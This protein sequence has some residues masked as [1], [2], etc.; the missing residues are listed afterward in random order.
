MLNQLTRSLAGSLLVLAVLPLAMAQELSAPRAQ[1]APSISLVA[2]AEG[3]NPVIAPNTWVEIKGAN[4]APANDTR[5][6]AGSDFVDNAL[7]VALD[8]VSVTVNGKPA[9]VYYISPIQINILTPPDAMPANVQVIVT[10]NGTHSTAYTA[11]AQP[12]SPSWFNFTAGLYVAARHLDNT[13]VGP[14]SLFPNLST[15]ATPN[16]MISIY[17]NGFGPTNVAIVSGAISQGGTLPRL[18][19]I[20]IGGLPAVVQFAG[21]IGPGEF[22]FNVIIPKNAPSGDLPIIATYNGVETSPVGLITVQGPTPMPSTLT[23][24]V[25]PNG[26]DSWSGRLP[27]P[28]SDNTDGP[29]AT[30]DHARASVQNVVKA[31][32]TEI[33]VR[34][35]AG[36]YYL[37]A[38][39]ML[40]A[41]DSGSASLKIV[42]E[43]YPGESPIISGGVRVQDWTNVSGNVWKATLPASIKYFENLFYNGV[44]RLR[45]RLGG[46]LGAYLRVAAVVYLDAPG[47][48]AAAPNA[49][50]PNYVAGQGWQCFDRFQYNSFDPIAG[51]WKNLAP[52]AGNACN[53][54]AGNSAIAGDIE[55]LI[56]EKFYTA[57]LR[58]SCIDSTKNIVFLTSATQTE[59]NSYAAEGFIPQHRYIIENVEDQLAQPGQWFLDRSGSPWTL[60]YLA[61][62][63]E[64]PNTDTVEIPQLTQVLAA[65]NLQY[66]TFQGLTFANDNYTIPAGAHTLAALG[67]DVTSAVSFQ[68]SQFITFDSSTVAHTS[69]AGIE[70]ISCLNAQSPAW[71]ILSSPTAVTAHNTIQNSAFYDLGTNAIRIGV[72]ALPAD[73]E[74]N[75]PQFTTV[76]NNVV[77]GY[78]RT[79]PET[80]GIVQYEGHNN[81][82]THNDVYDG[83]HQAI[84]ICFCSGNANTAPDG[85]DN[86]VS[87]N[88]TYN[89]HQGIMNDGGNI[90]IQTRNL[91]TAP[92]PPGNRILNNKVHD[93]TDA[94][95]MDSDGYGGDGIYIDTESGLVDVENN[96]VYRVSGSTMNFAAAPTAPNEPSTVTNN[97]FAFG[98]TSMLNDGAPYPIGTVPARADQVVMASNN[99]FYFDRSTSSSPVFYVQGGCTYSG[100][101]PYTSYQQW[102]SN[103][104]WRTDGTFAS[105]PDEFHIQP[106][107]AANGLCTGNTT[108]WT[109]LNL[110]GWQKLGEDA[111]SVI[112]NPVFK[113]PVYPNDDYSMPNGSPGI[114]FVVFDTTLPGRT[115]PVIHPPAVAATF[116]TKTYNPATDY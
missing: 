9:F 29:Y 62:P 5:I 105:D 15:P 97:I 87:F 18:P 75:L 32:L 19:S 22:Q 85:H 69:G 55:L 11:Q 112:K 44:R 51:T 103:L 28:N 88:H 70:F 113:N 78:G 7:P 48:P 80:A 86:V 33:D 107:N 27:S 68:N 101:F 1:P 63:G 73:T 53:E 38:T 84:A 92:A 43:N 16:E 37:P 115:N 46:Y 90:Y 42:Y 66:V 8:G 95:I 23:V 26:N 54:P 61:N 93:V 77:T 94:S 102:T 12:I 45:P 10:N 6:W 89:T 81:T 74:A 99:L 52:S 56:F 47:P 79:I 64:N 109:F 30:F 72:A 21:L 50:C 34:F 67:G 116:V 20:S 36:T 111:Q 57:K 76:Q 96:L 25:A 114:G 82:Y 104:Y 83:Y 59:S 106:A 35:R 2:N 98:R 60:T 71:C 41:A 58:I 100:G 3:E 49:N 39:E 24:Y 108:K 65:S 17:A 13:Y 4:L 31:G 14:A 40:T 110:A 91:Q